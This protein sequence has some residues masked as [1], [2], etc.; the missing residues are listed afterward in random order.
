M[1]SSFY[2]KIFSRSHFIKPTNKLPT[3][4]CHREQLRAVFNLKLTPPEL[5]ALI[6]HQNKDDKEEN[7]VNCA[8]FLVWFLRIGFEEKSRRIRATWAEKKRIN[9][10]K[11]RRRQE[12]LAEQAAKNSLKSSLDFA[13]EDRDRALAKLR[14][15]AKLYDKAM[16]GAMS[17]SSFEVFAM[18]PHVFKEQLRIVF[19]LRISPPEMGALMSVFD[20]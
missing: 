8:S 9:E 19:N 17:M 12:E 2:L 7:N 15:A 13:P 14:E 5:A 10:D 4:N 3:Q 6:R 11:D 1:F 16:P 18:P 20:G